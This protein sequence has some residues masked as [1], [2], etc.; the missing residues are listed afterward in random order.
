MPSKFAQTAVQVQTQQQTLSPQQVMVARLTELPVDGLRDRIQKEIED[1]Q[2]IEAKQ[3]GEAAGE[4]D[5]PASDGFN[6]IS[7][8]DSY[9]DSY[10]T[11]PRALPSGDTG[12]G[13]REDGDYAESFYDHLSK[14]L[15]EYNLTPRE[16]DIA[17]YLIGTLED[18]GMLRISLGQ[19]AD[20]LDIYQDIQTSEGELE[21][22]LTSV[23]QQMEPAG[24]GARSLQECLVIQA[25]RHYIGAE[26]DQLLALFTRNWDDFS[27]TRWGKLQAS[28]KLSDHELEQLRKRVRHMTPR[29]GG[30]IGGEHYAQSR[31]VTPDFFVSIGESGQLRLSLNEGDLP[32]LTLSPDAEVSLNMPVVT[33]ADR[34]AVR[35]LR[36]QV[37]SA[38]LFIDAIA[39]RRRSMLLTMKAIMK[40]QRAFFLTGDETRLKPMNLEDVSRLT[41]LDISTTSR[42]SNSKYVQTPHGTYPLRWF[43]TTA[44]IKDGGEVSVR[45]ILS[46][47]KNMVED[48][49]KAHPLS[50]EK[51]V[52]MLRA[53]GY[54][55]AR[56]TVA[57]YRTQLGIP[58]SRLR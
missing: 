22:L 4:A 55:I 21:R 1:N 26:R 35:Y 6:D 31:T 57:K 11:L 52:A 7:P 9:D 16:R 43:F 38:R 17:Q 23:I 28:M 19:I 37:A 53:K 39:Q 48:E 2:W 47:L 46:A 10:D 15:G 18:D 42:V 36:G 3:G 44:A 5:A 56:R 29:P 51:L 33:K 20:E 34:E 40:L 50:D 27:H 8:E 41:G 49:D 25:K 45:N 24:I 54:T 58:E 12:R 32:T 13:N 14:Q 30:S